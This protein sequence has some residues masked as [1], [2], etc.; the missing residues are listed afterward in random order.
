[1]NQRAIHSLVG[2]FL[3]TALALLLYSL[4]SLPKV[5]RLLTDVSMIRTWLPE[6]YVMQGSPVFMRNFRVGRVT[7]VNVHPFRKNEAGLPTAEWFEVMIAMESPWTEELNNQFRISVEIGLL[8][9]LTET[10]LVVLLPYEGMMG[11]F[12]ATDAE[13]IRMKDL[14]PGEILEL[15]FQP[16]LNFVGTAEDQLQRFVNNTLPKIERLLDRS[17]DL[18]ETLA[19]P[20]GALL[21]TLAHLERFSAGLVAELEQPNTDLRTLLSDLREIVGSIRSGEGLAGALIQ[22]AALK[23]QLE[24]ILA[25]TD[26]AMGRTDALFMDLSRTAAE[27]ARASQALPDL[28]QQL[29]ITLS[30][31]EIAS[32]SLPGVAEDVRRTIAETLKVLNAVERLPLIRGNIEQ[33]PLEV[34]PLILPGAAS[35]PASPRGGSP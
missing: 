35:P 7:E 18:A 12:P 24:R 34:P 17:A 28:T 9:N 33:V 27:V 2:L 10:R 8:G 31:F 23:G 19:D 15:E 3:L 21:Q 13:P 1:M 6:A 16:Q 11:P 26:S 29:R 14:P 5:R 4:Y 25:R 32:R 22:E 20:D 30:R